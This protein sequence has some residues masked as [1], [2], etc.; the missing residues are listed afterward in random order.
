MESLVLLIGLLLAL[1]GLACL[2]SSLALWL[3]AP[4]P[5]KSSMLVVDLRGETD[6]AGAL[7]ALLERLKNSGLSRRVW[8]AAVADEAASEN[9]RALRRFCEGTKIACGTPEELRDQLR[10]PPL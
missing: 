7:R 9:G 6:P 3:T 1:Y 2:L 10:M 4:G 8:L 5:R